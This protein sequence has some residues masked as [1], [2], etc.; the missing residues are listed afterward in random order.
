MDVSSKKIK[1]LLF[2]YWYLKVDVSTND[3]VSCKLPPTMSK[4]HTNQLTKADPR[5]SRNGGF[6]QSRQQPNLTISSKAIAR[7]D[8]P[9]SSFYFSLYLQVSLLFKQSVRLATAIMFTS[10]CNP[11][12]VLPPFRLFFVSI[13]QIHI[14]IPPLRNKVN[15]DA[16]NDDDFII[17]DLLDN[18]FHSQEEK[19][20][21]RVERWKQYFGKKKPFPHRVPRS[22]KK[23]RV[24]KVKKTHKK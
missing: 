22:K 11:H 12:S 6:G 15:I 14:M 18:P 9:H 2:I 5:A 13:T 4:V 8:R 20:K 7:V 10:I 21:A 3:L 17:S 16:E 23:R 19:L 1:L 24:R